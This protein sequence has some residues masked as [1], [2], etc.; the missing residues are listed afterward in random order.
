MRRSG[1]K[2]A[3]A[4]KAWKAYID[5]VPAAHGEENSKLLPR[6][7]RPELRAF[8]KQMFTDMLGG[9]G[10]AHHMTNA[11]LPSTIQID[12]LPDGDP[13]TPEIVA[14]SGRAIDTAAKGPEAFHQE[15]VRT[16][17]KPSRPPA[18]RVQ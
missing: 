15:F 18:D 13:M 12:P 1:P 14:R 3:E 4:K 8:S 5:A 6:F 7:T 11:P 9:Q 16:L 17:Q 2:P 10:L